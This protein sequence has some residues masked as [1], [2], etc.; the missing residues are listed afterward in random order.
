MHHAHRETHTGCHPVHP[1]EVADQRWRPTLHSPLQQVHTL[2]AHVGEYGA[3]GLRPLGSELHKP[4]QQL[5]TLHPPRTDTQHTQTRKPESWTAVLP[6][7]V[8]QGMHAALPPATSQTRTFHTAG[9]GVPHRRTMAESWLRRSVAGSLPWVGNKG[10]RRTIS[11]NTHPTL[12][13]ST[14]SQ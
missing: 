2:C 3:K 6:W 1:V 10:T 11:A 8:S 4:G 7:T 14:F 13:T 12:H 5:H 9:S